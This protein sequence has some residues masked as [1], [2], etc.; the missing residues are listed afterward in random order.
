MV[1]T[2]LT[3]AVPVHP[4]SLPHHE[5]ADAARRAHHQQRL[6]LGACAAAELGAYTA[7][8]H[9]ITG[10]TKSTALDGRTYDIACGQID[11]GN[12]ADRDDRSA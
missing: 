4:G 3:G 5:G 8:K 1:D 6:D 7:T 10:L 12:A 9:A 2:N 11:I